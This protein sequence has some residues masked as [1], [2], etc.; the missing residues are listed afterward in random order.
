M[1]SISFF[2]FSFSPSCRA[3]S[4]IRRIAYYMLYKTCTDVMQPIR[5]VMPM[6]IRLYDWFIYKYKYTYT[7]VAHC[8]QPTSVAIQGCVACVKQTHPGSQKLQWSQ[9]IKIEKYV[10][11]KKIKQ[12]CGNNYLWRYNNNHSNFLFFKH[13]RTS[14]I[15][16]DLCD[17]Y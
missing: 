2:F 10:E 16:C 7:Y 4:R 9:T 5:A 13:Y 3:R 17:W 14:T 15:L 1:K 6:Q 11:I 8:S 12:F